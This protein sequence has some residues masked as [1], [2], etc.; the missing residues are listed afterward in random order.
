MQGVK[1]GDNVGS[2]IRTKSGMLMKDTVLTNGCTHCDVT[3]TLSRD[4]DDGAV[5]YEVSSPASCFG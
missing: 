2:I 1:E 4:V 3:T 5:S